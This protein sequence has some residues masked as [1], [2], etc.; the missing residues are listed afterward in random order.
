[1][2]VRGM[3][4]VVVPRAGYVIGKER[5]LWERDAVLKAALEVMRPTLVLMRIDG[6]PQWNPVPQAYAGAMEDLRQRYE[7]RRWRRTDYT[8]IQLD[9]RDDRDFAIFKHFAAVSIDATAYRRL[10]RS[11]DFDSVDGA[12]PARMLLSAQELELIRHGL[13]KQGIDLPLHK[14]E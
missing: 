10:T 1:M 12:Q 2:A 3:S 11:P 14:E 8:G 4:G 5:N 6:Y 7:P 9:P 13:G